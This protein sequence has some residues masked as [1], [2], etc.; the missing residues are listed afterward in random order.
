MSKSYM[1]KVRGGADTYRKWDGSTVTAGNGA[2]VSEEVAYT[3]AASQDQTLVQVTSVKRC[4]YAD[5]EETR[6]SEVLR[7]MRRTD[8]QETIRERQA[9]KQSG[10]SSQEILRQEVHGEGV[11]RETEEERRIVD[12][13]SLPR[14]KDLPSESMRDMRVGEEYGSASQER[15][16]AGQQA[17]ESYEGVSELSRETTQKE[18]GMFD[19]R[20]TP[21]GIGILREA[22]P[23]IQ[24][25][26][27]PDDDSVRSEA[28]GGE[29]VQE[30]VVR[31]LTPL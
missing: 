25:V 4:K 24:E 11:F 2:L 30:Y 1:L 16:L 29:E 21:E 23:E 10:V 13:S 22:L 7:G 20:E 14:K 26:R 15:K 3:L 9:G 27:R 17:R 31:R 6:R 19:M 8:E 5:E 12:D 28:V 18:G